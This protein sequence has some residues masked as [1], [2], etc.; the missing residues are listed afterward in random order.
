[1]NN[2]VVGHTHDDGDKLFFEVFGGSG[3]PAQEFAFR[4]ASM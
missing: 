1:M 3:V 2:Y 4:G